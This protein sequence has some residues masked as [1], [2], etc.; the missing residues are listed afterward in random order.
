MSKLSSELLTLHME[1]DLMGRQL[2]RCTRLVEGTHI[3]N[4][5]IH[6]RLEDMNTRVRALYSRSEDIYK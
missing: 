6:N 5:A 2:D 1:H 4:E 3:R